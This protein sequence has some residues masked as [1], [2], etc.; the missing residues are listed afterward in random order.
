[1]SFVSNLKYERNRRKLSSGE[2]VEVL[3]DV[4]RGIGELD[5]SFVNHDLEEVLR[6]V[7]TGEHEVKVSDARIIRFNL[8]VARKV[9]KAYERSSFQPPLDG[10]IRA[11]RE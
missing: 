8:S 11:Y 9:M 1:M 6:I 3:R 10:L 7:R 4:K 2:A 5:P